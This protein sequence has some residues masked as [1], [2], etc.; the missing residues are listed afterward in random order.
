MKAYFVFILIFATTFVVPLSAQG[1]L[2]EQAIK[3]LRK[4]GV[5]Q[6]EVEKRLLE[7]GYDPYEIDPDNPTELLEI[8]RVTEEIIAEIKSEQ[9]AVKELGI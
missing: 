9:L 1:D 8:Q 5:D 3:E 7:R 6:S 4:Q 2:E